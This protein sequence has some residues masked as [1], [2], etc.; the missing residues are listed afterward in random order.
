MS[1]WDSIISVCRT[2]THE[3]VEYGVLIGLGVVLSPLLLITTVWCVSRAL[4]W[5]WRLFQGEIK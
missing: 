3:E 1:I 4:V 5:L 2:L